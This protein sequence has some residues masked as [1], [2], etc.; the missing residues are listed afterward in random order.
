MI[1]LI[2]LKIIIMSKFMFEVNNHTD[3][4]RIVEITANTKMEAIDLLHAMYSKNM[5]YDYKF[6][7]NENN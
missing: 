3:D 4:Y 1:W 5:G 7:D 6:I 2:L